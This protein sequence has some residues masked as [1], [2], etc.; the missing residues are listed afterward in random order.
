MTHDNPEWVILSQM[1]QNTFEKLYEGEESL[2]NTLN[3]L[4]IELKGDNKINAWDYLEYKDLFDVPLGLE[5]EDENF[6][7]KICEAYIDYV[8]KEDK[9]SK[10]LTE[11]KNLLKLKKLL[12]KEDIVSTIGV[13][14]ANSGEFSIDITYNTYIKHK[15]INFKIAK[16]FENS[17]NKMLGE[18]KNAIFS[19]AEDK[20][21]EAY[22][23]YISD[24]K[25]VC[26]LYKQGSL[27]F[28]FKHPNYH[29]AGYCE[30]FT[31]V[32]YINFINTQ[33]LGC[34]K[35]VS[36]PELYDKL[37]SFIGLN[38]DKYII[39][40]STPPRTLSSYSFTIE[41][42]DDSSITAAEHVEIAVVIKDNLLKK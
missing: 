38:K 19:L 30:T 17:F 33:I 21:N 6:D 15:D 9:E 7:T 1:K 29:N 3:D 23:L 16:K 32:D 25:I 5:T 2:N 14:S 18:Q 42:K 39:K 35:E 13:G 8:V 24:N 11:L 12:K 20:L 37:I 26:A 10:E 4:G 34:Q 41:K 22:D 40:R 27:R 31:N 36:K 28:G